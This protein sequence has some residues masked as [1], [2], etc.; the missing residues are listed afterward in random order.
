[1]ATH[2]D[3]YCRVSR[4]RAGDAAIDPRRSL[5]ILSRETSDVQ[6]REKYFVMPGNNSRRRA[7]IVTP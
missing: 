7:P 4:L 3:R 2:G 1:M 5:T 6:A